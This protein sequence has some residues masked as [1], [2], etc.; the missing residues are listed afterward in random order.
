MIVM[1][2]VLM[3]VSTAWRGGRHRVLREF[4]FEPTHDLSHRSGLVLFSRCMLQLML[5]GSA[6]LLRGNELRVVAL[7]IV[8]I[9][10]NCLMIGSLLVVV[11]HEVN[12]VA[13][14]RVAGSR[15]L[16]WIVVDRCRRHDDVTIQD[17]RV[18]LRGGMYRVVPRCRVPCFPEIRR[19]RFRWCFGE[20][21]GVMSRCAFPDRFV[22]VGSCLTRLQR[23]LT[24][25]IIVIRSS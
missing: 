2:Y 19:P 7:Q 18:R 6:A 21:R 22:V 9:I 14:G 1:V 24:V 11:G 12:N 16:R 20:G 25:L 17:L 13:V 10:G 8:V 23:C 15:V 3:N 5:L 4:A